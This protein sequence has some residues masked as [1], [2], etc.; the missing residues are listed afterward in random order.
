VRSLLQ[1]LYEVRMVNPNNPEDEEFIAASG[2]IDA[3]LR[4]LA[5]DVI[6]RLGIDKENAL[7]MLLQ[8][9]SAQRYSLSARAPLSTSRAGWSCPGM[10]PA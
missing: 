8:R 5:G 7:E 4:E 10:A 2:L 6:S 9:L 3:T 1:T